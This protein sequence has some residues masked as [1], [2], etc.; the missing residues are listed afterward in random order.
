MWRTIIH[1]AFIVSAI[2]ISRTDRLMQMTAAA[3]RNGQHA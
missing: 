3:G 1:M 2:G